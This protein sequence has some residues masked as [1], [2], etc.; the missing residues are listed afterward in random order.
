MLALDQFIVT[1][2]IIRHDNKL[3]DIQ[4]FHAVDFQRV[5][6]TV[7]FMEPILLKKYRNP[8]KKGVITRTS[9]IFIN[10]YALMKTRHNFKDITYKTNFLNDYED[11]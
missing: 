1:F 4:N 11:I 6:F 2:E 7:T 5:H 3:L 9:F 8:I 10:R